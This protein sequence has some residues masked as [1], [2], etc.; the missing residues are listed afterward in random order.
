M[1]AMLVAGGLPSSN[2]ET[3]VIAVP[4]LH[5]NSTRTFGGGGTDGDGGGGGDS[6]GTT[7]DVRKDAPLDRVH[8]C[9]LT[10]KCARHLAG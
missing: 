8:T 4:M 1:V 5:S 7:N 10:P 3:S 9:L 2:L 6:G